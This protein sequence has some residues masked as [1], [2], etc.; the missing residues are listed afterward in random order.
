M[1]DIVRLGVI[2]AGLKAADYARSWVRMPEVE[3]VAAADVNAASRQR[4]SEIC[5]EAGRPAPREFE[6]YRSMLAGCAGD[7]DAVYISTPHAFHGEQAIAVVEAG[8]DLFLEKPMVATVAEA[9]A[10]IE[11]RDR[12]GSVV[13]VAYNGVLSPLV[14]DTHARAMAGEFGEL[15]S[16]SA[17]IWESWASNYDGHW[18]QRP[19][20]SGGG[21]VFDTG[22]HMM[23]TVC[24]LVDSGFERVSA[25]MNNR[26][27]PVDI[28]TAV[29]G[30]LENGALVTFNAAGEGPKGC[31]SHMTLFYSKAIVRID[32]WGA[33]REISLD[34]KPGL[35]E[36]AATVQ[37]ENPLRSFLGVRAGQEAN[38]ST[39]E[40]GLRFARLWDAIKASAAK[41]GEPVR[42]A[43]I[44]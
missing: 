13:V 9:N 36:E 10:L 35:R 14:R 3:F 37:Q 30:R 5:L 43:D 38:P 20:L 26:G 32:A 31:A 12:A 21:F 29:A 17:T 27:K 8:L 23:N 11:A 15:V 4:L 18:K 40:N 42:I 2:G 1:P 33:W 34:G 22:A 19:E 44:G 39:V 7:I 16:V 28:V 6:D 41:D 24:F 25:Y